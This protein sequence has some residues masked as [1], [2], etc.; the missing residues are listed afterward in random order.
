MVDQKTN[1]NNDNNNSTRYKHDNSTRCIKTPAAVM[2]N[3]GASG[4]KAIPNFITILSEMKNEAT[5]QIY[6]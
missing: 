4:W 5:L 1:N 6:L 2:E 3:S